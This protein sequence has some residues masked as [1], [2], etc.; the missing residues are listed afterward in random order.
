[1][2]LQESWGIYLCFLPLLVQFFLLSLFSFPYVGR[3]SHPPPPVMHT[4][5]LKTL[6]P[7]IGKTCHVTLRRQD[8]PHSVTCPLKLKE[9]LL[10]VL[11]SKV[12]TGFCVF[13]LEHCGNLERSAIHL[14]A[15]G[16]LLGCCLGQPCTFEA[17]F[18]FG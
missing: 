1:M 6:S 11:P 4:Q 8:H 15:S 12:L 18:L 17:S 16:S 10:K 5:N 2:A 14:T 9:C 7:F 13:P 3:N